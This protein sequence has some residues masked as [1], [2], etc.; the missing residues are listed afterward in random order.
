MANRPCG[1]PTARRRD[2]YDHRHE[3]VTGGTAVIEVSGGVHWASSRAVASNPVAQ[4]ATV[5]Y[6][7]ARTSVALL[8]DW[9]RECGYHCAGQSVPRHVCGDAARDTA[10]AAIAALQEAGVQ[11]VMLTG[12]NRSTADRIAGH[13][14]S[15]GC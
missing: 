13:S 8:A 1:L 10:A 14:A 9:V 5:T 4:T 7:P 6:D 15:T 2:V 3:L 12:D 11:V